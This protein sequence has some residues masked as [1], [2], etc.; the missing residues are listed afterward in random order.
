MT[1][2]HETMP[3]RTANEEPVRDLPIADARESFESNGPSGEQPRIVEEHHI[4]GPDGFD[5]IEAIDSRG[6]RWYHL[7]PEPRG[8]ADLMGVNHSWWLLA[9]VALIVVLLPW[10]WWY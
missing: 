3:M 10:G 7:R 2:T 4:T 1:D 8:R 6:R 9:V 5:E